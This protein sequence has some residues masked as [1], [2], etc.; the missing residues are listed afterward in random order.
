MAKGESHQ[1]GSGLE[2]SPVCTGFLINQAPFLMAMSPTHNAPS[3][4]MIIM[5]HRVTRFVL[6]HL[7]KNDTPAFQIFKLT[8]RPEPACNY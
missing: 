3:L 7:Y 8:L 4:V 6:A 2:N 5:Q 1:E